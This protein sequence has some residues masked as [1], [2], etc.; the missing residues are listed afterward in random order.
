MFRSMSML[1]VALS[2][3]VLTTRADAA[4]LSLVADNIQLGVSDGATF[5]TNQPLVFGPLVT[6]NFQY[7]LFPEPGDPP[8]FSFPLPRL[9]VAT[10]AAI[11]PAQGGSVIDL[12]AGPNLG[13]FSNYT[14]PGSVGQITPT[15][16]TNFAFLGF[17]MYT[18]SVSTFL[19][20][21]VGTPVP[22][23]GSIIIRKSATFT[24]VAVP[25]PSP[26]PGIVLL[27]GTFIAV[28]QRRHKL[29]QA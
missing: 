15:F 2:I 10:S 8:P 13:F 9:F 11:S 25:E 18:L 12:N 7:N 3:A 23:N 21:S 5:I 4:T 26:L 29:N 20:G 27:G 17:G 16:G 24:I 19:G 22:V 6:G 1:T 14:T 28:L